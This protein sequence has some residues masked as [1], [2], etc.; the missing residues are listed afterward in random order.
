MCI[1]FGPIYNF[2]NKMLSPENRIC[3]NSMDVNCGI[4]VP[5][6][7][8]LGVAESDCPN[9]G[10]IPINNDFVLPLP[11]DLGSNHTTFKHWPNIPWKCFFLVFGSPMIQFK[12]VVNIIG[13]A[14]FYFQGISIK[15][16]IAMLSRTYGCPISK[17][18]GPAAMELVGPPFYCVRY[19]RY[20]PKLDKLFS[21]VSILASASD[22]FLRSSAITC[23]GAF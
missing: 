20:Q 6:L 5:F 1:S 2:R 14:S 22:C 17:N 13:D 16:L 23:S 11:F 3:C 8:Y 4:L 21:K 18:S 15:R 19:D 10:H 9:T 12:N 7:P